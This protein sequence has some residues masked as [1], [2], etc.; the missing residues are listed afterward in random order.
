MLSF[1]RKL[2]MQRRSIAEGN[3]A[4]TDVQWREQ[5]IMKKK[6]SKA[7]VQVIF[8]LLLF[9]LIFMAELYTML[10]YPKQFIVLVVMTA[11]DLLCLFV[12]VNGIMAIREMKD[13]RR[14]EQYESIF[15]SQKASYLMLKK[16]F[17]EI[18]DKLLYLEEASKIPTEEIINAQKGIAKVIVKRS[19]ENTEALI[20]ADDQI[21]DLINQLQKSME[22][23]VTIAGSFKDEIL[24][25]QKGVE[26]VQARTLEVK[27]QDLVTAMKDMELR[28]N[29]AMN[30]KDQQIVVN[31]PPTP[32]TAIVQPVQTEPRAAVVQPVQTELQ[33][34]VTQ[35][36]QTESQAA[37][38]QPVQTE[39]QVVSAES[40]QK[41]ISE[42]LILDEPDLSIESEI[43]PE[44]FIE[45]EDI[46]SIEPEGN[47]E[48]NTDFMTGPVIE[49]ELTTQPE[50]DSDLLTELEA[51][52]KE[53]EEPADIESAEL[54]PMPDLSDPN[55]SMSADEIAA[56]F[57]NMGS[58]DQAA[59][60][61]PV[62]EPI[63]E[64]EPEP[65]PIP[66]PEPVPEP[67][68]VQEPESI[69][70]QEPLT[71]DMSDPNKQL[72]PDEIAALF[73]SMGT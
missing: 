42:D 22:G 39:P 68:S 61:E 21:T 73:A 55:R 70:E 59:G 17:E 23:F 25:A 52:E 30:N 5:K 3:D 27:M 18:E 15:K 41:T 51:K 43:E 45:P 65:E 4:W 10:N 48:S 40:E 24:E 58:N 8:G 44:Q 13:D 1:C 20:S 46:D 62:S 35:P 67:E 50:D 11:A 63:P 69:P 16:Y 7:R 31:V 53:S 66:E 14:E 6:D 49:P 60:S 34:A 26:N 72:S 71:V 54:P 28:L 12:V 57:A 37:V 64:P 36:V 29:Q 9:A 32:Q 47:E 2:D 19:H 38:T 33:A 56:L